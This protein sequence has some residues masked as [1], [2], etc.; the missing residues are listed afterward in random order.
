MSRSLLALPIT[1]GACV[2]AFA[3]T[4][5]PITTPTPLWTISTGLAAPESA[6]YHEPSN[7]IFVSN[8]NGQVLEKDGNG[9]I[10]RIR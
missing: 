5:P 1:I 2:A 9:Y 7:S 6:Y 4:A 10:T 8:I 3:Q